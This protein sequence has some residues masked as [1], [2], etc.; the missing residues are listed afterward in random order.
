MALNPGILR[1]DGVKWV[2]DSEINVQGPAGPAGTQGSPG[3]TGPAGPSGANSTQLFRIYTVGTSGSITADYVCD[4]IN[5][6]VQINQAITSAIASNPIR[7]VVRL[8]PGTYSIGAPI[9][10]KSNVVL[11]GSGVGATK[12]VVSSSFVES[13]IYAVG[14]LVSEIGSAI[15]LASNATYGQQI[16]SCTAGTDLSAV[17]YE[18]YLFLLSEA[19]WEVSTNL[20]IPT[21]RTFDFVLVDTSIG[22]SSCSMYPSDIASLNL[23]SA[24]GIQIMFLSIILSA[25]WDVYPNL[26]VS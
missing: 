16:L 22:I 24:V 23:S 26:S 9:E 11:E 2:I 13:N 18:D 8:L 17:A 21:M 3:A 7:S 10:L 12:I 25:I 5:D 6:E 19:L 1:F 4:G 15:N 14:A 20:F